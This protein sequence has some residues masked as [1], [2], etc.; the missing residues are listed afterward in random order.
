MRGV[1]ARAVLFLFLALSLAVCTSDASETGARLAAGIARDDL[2]PARG[3]C[4]PATLNGL[5]TPTLKAQPVALAPEVGDPAR[6]SHVVAG[7][8]PAPSVSLP[9][10]PPHEGFASRAPPRP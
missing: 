1:A 6:P 7:I 8:L 10:Y 4:G 5:S 9:R 2:V 3:D